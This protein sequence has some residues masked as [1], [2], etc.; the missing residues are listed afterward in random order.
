MDWLTD[1]H[2]FLIAV[3]FY[4]FSMIYSVFLWRKGFREDNR[5]NYFLLFIACAFHT[6]AMVKRGFSLQRCPVNNLY[7]ATISLPGRLWRP[8]WCLAPGRGCA[9]WGRLPRPFC[10]SWAFSR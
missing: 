6:T 9:F 10:L 5:V 7:E 1:K 2:Y 8:I 4:G 3:I